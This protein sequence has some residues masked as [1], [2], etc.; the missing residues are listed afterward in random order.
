M[1]AYMAGWNVFCNG[2]F[3]DEDHYVGI[4]ESLEALN[5]KWR[6]VF[7]NMMAMSLTHMPRKMIGSTPTVMECRYLELHKEGKHLWN[8]C[9]A[10]L[11]Q[12]KL[13][14]ASSY[15]TVKHM[16][17][18]ILGVRSNVVQSGIDWQRGFMEKGNGTLIQQVA[19]TAFAQGTERIFTAGDFPAGVG[20]EISAPTH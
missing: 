17:D 6:F 12:S 9:F 13:E 18:V 4:L 10:S 16:P 11:Y 19:I 20:W 3:L 2:P 1:E 5:N 8:G 14:H 7:W 15:G